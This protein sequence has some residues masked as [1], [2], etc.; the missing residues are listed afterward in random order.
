MA[1]QSR[2]TAASLNKHLIGMARAS[3]A[4]NYLASPLTGGGIPV[5]RLQQLF[6]LAIAGGMA[7]PAD[8]A[9]SAWALLGQQGQRVIK[10]GKTLEGD[11]ANLAEIELRAQDFAKRRLPLLKTLQIL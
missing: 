2:K 4:I 10:D 3:P 7:Q 6:L 11:A 8:W 1:A 9:K 5:E